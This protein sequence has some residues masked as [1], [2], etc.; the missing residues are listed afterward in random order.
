M[1]KVLLTVAVIGSA[2]VANASYLVWQVSN[3]DASGYGTEWDSAQVVKVADPG[4]IADWNVGDKRSALGAD[5]A[6]SG[7]SYTYDGAEMFAGSVGV[8]ESGSANFAVNIGD[9]S[10]GS[11]AFYIELVNYNSG[12]NNVYARSEAIA[13]NSATTCFTDSLEVVQVPNI[14]AWHP[15]S[16]TVVPEPTSAM[17]MLFGAAFLGLKRKNRSLA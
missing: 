2:I 14:A 13:Y 12:A 10:T 7:A 4:T 15:N 9:V 1:K 8:P 16:Y 17:L 5:A 3:I 11:Y 6:I